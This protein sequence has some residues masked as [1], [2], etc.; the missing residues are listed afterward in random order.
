MLYKSFVR[1][2]L[3]TCRVFHHT[4]VQRHMEPGTWCV[5]EYAAPDA[6]RAYAGIF[7]LAG[8]EDDA[9]QFQPRGLDVS[10]R[11]RVVLDNTGRQYEADGHGLVDS[12]VRV[13]VPGPLQSELLLF[14]AI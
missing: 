14:E 12:G 7:R 11:Y 5:L 3:S 6:S 8:G 4:P 13:R 2:M 9:Y 10:R 1:P